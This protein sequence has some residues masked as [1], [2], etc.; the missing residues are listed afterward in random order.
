MAG[1]LLSINQIGDYLKSNGF[2]H[3][4]ILEQRDFLDVPT[5]YRVN[6]NYYYNRIPEKKSFTLKG[7][8]EQDV[9]KDRYT[10][11]FISYWKSMDRT[12]SRYL[13]SQGVPLN[14]REMTE[15]EGENAWE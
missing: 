7:C 8:I 9:V 10:W 15:L 11:V 14:Y 2:F 12:L 13:S 5:A 4:D 3:Y 1:L 6:Y